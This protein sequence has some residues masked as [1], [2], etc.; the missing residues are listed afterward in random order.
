MN[1]IFT[2][3]CNIV[4]DLEI[5]KF[6]SVIFMNKP[7]VTNMMSPTSTFLQRRNLTNTSNFKAQ[8][9]LQF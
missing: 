6:V 8:F 2:K 5:D 9:H 7:N 3:T 4:V 1:P